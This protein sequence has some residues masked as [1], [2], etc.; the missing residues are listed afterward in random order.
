MKQ[1]YI[2]VFFF[3]C[4]QVIVAQELIDRISTYSGD[5]IRC[6]ITSLNN[7]S[8]FFKTKKH[9]QIIS[10]SISEVKSYEWASQYIPEPAPV[11]RQE[12]YPNYYKNRFIFSLG[13]SEHFSTHY[14]HSNLI[15]SCL[16]KGHCV[17]AGPEYTLMQKNFLESL[18]DPFTVYEN[19]YGGMNF[20]YR[21]YSNSVWKETKIFLQLNFSLFRTTRYRYDDLYVERIKREWVLEYFADAA[22]SYDYSRK[23]EVYGGAG[24]G[25]S[26][27][28]PHVFIGLSY[29][30]TK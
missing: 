9:G 23:V 25:I 1:L 29:T 12:Y 24:F 16:Y 26:S 10:I 21:Y 15:A 18:E 27:L 11:K 14:F 8:I 5:T 4:T 17:Y 13:L 3:F 22:V 20:G 6:K 28:I 7:Q 2:S 30:I 19:Q